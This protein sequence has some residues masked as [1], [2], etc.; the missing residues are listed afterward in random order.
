MTLNQTIL[1]AVAIATIVPLVFLYLIRKLD[2]YGTGA[3]RTVLACFVWGLVAFGGAL[4]VNQTMLDNNIVTEDFFRQ[5]SAPVIEEILK[6]LILIYLVRRVSFT[7]FVDGAIY[8][9]ASGIGFAIIEN[10][11]YVY[12][13]QNAAVGLAVARVIST[14]LMHASASALVGIMLGKSRFEKFPASVGFL[15]GGYAL[16]MGLHIGYNNLVTRVSNSGGLLLLYAAVVGFS[17]AGIIAWQIRRGLKEE[18]AW[19]QEK[20]GMADLVTASETEIVNRFAELDN[21]LLKKFSPQ[22]ASRI[23]RFVTL[24]AQLG[25]KRKTLDRLPDANLRAAVLADMDS[26]RADMN[27]IRQT[28][29]AYIMLYVRTTFPQD[30]IQAYT[31]VADK[32][33]QQAAQPSTGP[34]LFARLDNKVTG[35]N[36]KIGPQEPDKPNG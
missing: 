21:L 31:I 6:S 2:L 1:V 23:K 19:I 32:I 12:T 27:E 26:L 3:F 29:G 5:F 16:A 28:L 35:T 30:E 25:I 24:Q 22:V 13:H 11:Y 9:F 34:S 8:G 20:L 14:N 4:L 18:K 33:S 36:P 7:Y 10:Y 15:L 17:A